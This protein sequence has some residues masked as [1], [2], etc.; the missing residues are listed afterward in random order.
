MD[1]RPKIELEDLL[2]LKR[3]EKPDSGFWNEFDTGL[4][5]KS[6]EALAKKP[7]GFFRSLWAHK[8]MQQVGV[9]AALA[10]CG[11]PAY[12]GVHSYYASSEVKPDLGESTLPV[13]VASV[14]VPVVD[15]ATI[16]RNTRELE[17]R[18]RASASVDFVVD[19]YAVDPFGRRLMNN[20]G[21]ADSGF[22]RNANRI[23]V[24]DLVKALPRDSAVL[25]V[26]LSY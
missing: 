16:E 3:H 2:K 25:P 7:D 26:S 8:W 24:H 6:L 9:A 15:F 23:Y 18:K 20:Q 19:S 10:M 13:M 4:R 1:Q 14:E 22:E 5:R 21:V 11:V 17:S 12:F